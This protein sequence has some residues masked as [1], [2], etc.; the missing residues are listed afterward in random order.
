MSRRSPPQSETASS[1]GYK[2]EAVDVRKL[3]TKVVHQLQT[4]FEE[5]GVRFLLKID[6]I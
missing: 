3:R 5:E 4:H 1:S 2:G 6:S